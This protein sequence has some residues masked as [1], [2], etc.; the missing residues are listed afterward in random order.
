MQ[1]GESWFGFDTIKDLLSV[2]QVVEEVITNGP[3]S[4]EVYAL[5]F[6]AFTHRFTPVRNFHFLLVHDSSLIDLKSVFASIDWVGQTFST[7]TSASGE[8]NMS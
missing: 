5:D 4:W 1:L 3:A 8:A 2:H 7:N 6:E